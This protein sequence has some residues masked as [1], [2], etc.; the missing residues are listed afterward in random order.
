MS[1]VRIFED[2]EW[3]PYHTRAQLE[4]DL[5]AARAKLVVPGSMKCAKCAFVLTRVNL[6]VQNGAMGPGNNDTEPCPNGCGPLWPET[7]EQ[8]A[9][10]AWKS[11]EKAF[12]DLA[13]ERARAER[14]ENILAS[15]EKQ[16]RRMTEEAAGLRADA[17]RYRWLRDRGDD[18]AVEIMFPDD[19]DDGVVFDWDRVSGAEL[20]AAIEAAR[21][22]GGE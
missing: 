19:N 6:Y 1:D 10:D 17:E 11:A 13:A 3:V 7:W 16:I 2:Q 4:R 18:Y 8:A 22:G 21:A 14:A 9:R 5:A 15:H 12:D 20:D